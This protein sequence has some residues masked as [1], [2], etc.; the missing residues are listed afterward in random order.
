[1]KIDFTNSVLGKETIYKDEYSA[2]ILF[3]IARKLQRESH[4]IDASFVGF[5]LWN[6]YEFTYLDLHRKPVFKFLQIKICA[7]SE[8]LIESKSFKLYLYS[9]A[10]SSF[11]SIIEV[12][13][14]I[15]EDLARYA[16][17]KVEVKSFDMDAREFR[18]CKSS[19]VYL[20]TLD[21][22]TD[23]YDI[24]SSLLEIDPLGAIVTEHLT[25]NVLKS[26]CLATKQ[27]D[28]GSIEII[29]TG[30]KIVHDSLLRYLVSFRKHVGFHEDCVESIYTD[31]LK[32]CK[33]QVLTVYARY[34]RR[35]SLDINPLRSNRQVNLPNSRTFRQ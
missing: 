23:V 7:Q 19:A 12:E 21:V 32:R 30:K 33:P 22:V 16:N 34:T 18:L 2:D 31:I 9:F 17:G 13:K 1:M 35:G 11:Q 5:D 29:Y 8:N 20:D 24:D 10:N 14:V 15:Q 6:C 3:P 25:S 4:A 27:P 26:N 28:W